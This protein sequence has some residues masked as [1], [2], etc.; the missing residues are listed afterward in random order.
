MNDWPRSA[1]WDF[2]LDIYARPGVAAA[3]LALQDRHGLDVNLLLA[4]LFLGTQ[5]RVLSRAALEQ[6]MD[7]VE[8]LH[9]RV[10]R[11]L[12]AAR[13]ELKRQVE[14][15]GV[16]ADALVRLRAQLKAAELDAEHIEQLMIE[17]VL[18]PAETAPGAP[19]SACHGNLNAY[20]AAMRVHPDGA[21]K[22]ALGLLVAAART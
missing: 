21:D 11:P 13:R 2:S 8:A 16:M 18:A 10:I 22:A 17:A 4:C 3:C 19:V 20:L 5:G 9:A 12:R 15:G 7:E 6:A 1:F 14:G